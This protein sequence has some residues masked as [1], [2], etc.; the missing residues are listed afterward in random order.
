MLSAEDAAGLCRRLDEYG[1]RFWVI[2]GWGVDALLRRETRAHQDLDV[3]VLLDDLPA[4]GRMLDADGFS[5]T[6]VRDESHRVDGAP[7][8]F[9]AA[10]GRVR[11]LELLR[12]V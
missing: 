3:L 5:R 10:D 7:T 8:A 11:D 1:V 2:G 4:L 9:V 12:E 6:L